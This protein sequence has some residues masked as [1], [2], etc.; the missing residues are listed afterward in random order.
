MRLEDHAMRNRIAF[1]ITSLAVLLFV[2]SPSTT[3]GQGKGKGGQG[4]FDPTGSGFGGPNGGFP[5]GGF[6]GGNFNGGFGG[7]GG[8]KGNKGGGPNQMKGKKG[9][10]PGGFQGFP[11]GGFPD[12]GMAGGGFGGQGPGGFANGPGGFSNFGGPKG[13]NPMDTINQMAESDFAMRDRNGDG[14]L[15][16]DEMPEQLRAELGR[17]DTNRD[18]LI[19]LD[20]YKY[21]F[22]TRMQGGRGGNQQNNSIVTI[23]EE[24][25]L[26]TR[27]VV[28]RAGRLPK[29]LPSWFKEL[30]IDRDGQVA[31]YEWRLGKKEIDEFADWDRNNDGYITPEEALYK[32][33]IM[34]IASAGSRSDDGEGAA[35]MM[36][37]MGKFTMDLNGEGFGGGPGGGKGK[38]GGGKK[39]KE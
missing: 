32:Q 3:M 6:P 1:A 4:G 30:D 15:N 21:Y 34:Q 10:G 25:D 20:E 13:G 11:G 38:K 29:E 5:G 22:A 7:P 31:L 26:D 18:N 19:S 17:W 12:N 24:E 33:R 35:P 27:P 16:P 14:F 36:K 37:K 8:G 2:L 9:G 39:F 28:F 23:I